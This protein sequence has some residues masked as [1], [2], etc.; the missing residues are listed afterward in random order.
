MTLDEFGA[1]LKDW[2]RRRYGSEEATLQVQLDTDG[3]AKISI[4]KV[5]SKLYEPTPFYIDYST[6][7]ALQISQP[8]LEHKMLAKGERRSELMRA[9]I[10]D[11]ESCGLIDDFYT[12]FTITEDDRNCLERF[13]GSSY[14]D[15]R[16]EALLALMFGVN[17]EAGP[18]FTGY[19][20]DGLILH[21]LGVLEDT[22][23]EFTGVSVLGELRNR[24]D[25]VAMAVLRLLETNEKWRRR[26][27]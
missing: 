6:N 20:I 25:K 19:A 3:K 8:V 21:L 10:K 4:V 7:D 13:L 9:D 11:P 27:E 14:L 5:G 15:T 2:F 23:S 1:A 18:K 17:K 16:R 24:G 22:D 26:F 12:D